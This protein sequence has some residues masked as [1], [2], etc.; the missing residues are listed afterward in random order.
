MK[1]ANSIILHALLD[2]NGYKNFEEVK[3]TLI[4]EVFKKISDN[5]DTRIEYFRIVIKN[6][7]ENERNLF[8]EALKEF[9]EG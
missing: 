6:L 9:L 8:E 4:N 1:N 2:S 7:P 3:K 5:F